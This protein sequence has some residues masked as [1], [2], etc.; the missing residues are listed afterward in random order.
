MTP[1]TLFT[2]RVRH[3]MVTGTVDIK[4]VVPVNPYTHQEIADQMMQEYVTDKSQVGKFELVEVVSR[5]AVTVLGV[6]PTKEG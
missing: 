6:T 2:L 5:E 1:G 3:V 4:V